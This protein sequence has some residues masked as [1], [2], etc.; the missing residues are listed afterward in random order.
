MQ[1]E[2]DLTPENMEL[3]ANSIQNYVDELLSVMIIPDD[4][5]KEYGKLIEESL[6]ETKK[7]I[8]KLKKGDTSVFKEEYQ[9]L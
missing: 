6:K 8:K 1:L 9:D 4:L 2:K 3:L 7:L 5:Q